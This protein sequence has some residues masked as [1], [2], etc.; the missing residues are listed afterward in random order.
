MLN[1]VC[2]V[3]AKI[4][5]DKEKRFCL[6][7]ILF[8]MAISFS[9]LL[10]D[11]FRLAFLLFAL[12]L[13]S[14]EQM[15]VDIIRFWRGFTKFSGLLLICLAAWV[16]CAPLLGG[17]EP[18][19]ER[20][21]G[22]A[23]PL[24]VTL[25]CISVLVFARNY[26]FEKMLYR[27]SL[28]SI[29]V[30]SITVFCKRVMVDFSAVRGGW[31]FDMRADIV[32]N[33]LCMLMPW[34]LYA[35]FDKQIKHSFKIMLCMV[36]LLT[37]AMVWVT[38]IR[39]FWLGL[40]VQLISAFILLVC[41]LNIDIRKHIYKLCLIMAILLIGIAISYHCIQ[42]VRLNFA[43]SLSSSSFSTFSSR[44]D[45][46]WKEALSIIKNRKLLGYGWTDYDVFT[47]VFKAPHPHS[48]YL[49]AAFCT[50][51]IG[52]IL[53]IGVLFSFLF[54]SVCNLLKRRGPVIISFVVALVIIV[55]LV[56]GFTESFF[57]VGRE[58]LIPFWSTLA[59]LISP[60]YVRNDQ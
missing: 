57:Y 2:L 10:N 59:L 19:R 24:E 25:F 50:G 36:T 55:N 15:T 5:H 52:G 8:I 60:L 3:I 42:E 45:V 58:Y 32:A 33:L 17:V 34:L 21:M 16:V 51:I 28:L 7:Q 38:Y 30:F 46:V 56:V 23:R 1:K 49:H 35:L 37:I 29:V 53:Y 48:S 27:Y 43:Q 11:A 12:M 44:R 39:T 41:C 13:C 22:M 26:F 14:K 31:L 47:T 40:I 18:V 6:A 54:L 20:I 9:W 4:Y